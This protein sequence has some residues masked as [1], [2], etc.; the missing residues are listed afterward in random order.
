MSCLLVNNKYLIYLFLSPCFPEGSGTD[1][2]KEGKYNS[3]LISG[4]ALFRLITLRKED[5]KYYA[6]FFDPK[7]FITWILWVR[8]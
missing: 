2:D 3:L 8:N 1:A 4:A 6:I 7:V 5:S